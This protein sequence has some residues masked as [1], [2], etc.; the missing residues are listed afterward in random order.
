L[1]IA[2]ALN[3]NQLA[4]AQI[5]GVHACPDELD[6]RQISELA[7][8]ALLVKANFNPDEPRVPAGNPDGGEWTDSGE[9]AEVAAANDHDRKNKCIEECLYLLNR[10]LPYR[11]SNL[12]EFAFRR[13]VNECMQQTA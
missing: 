13:C 3:D 5:Y 2:E 6:D 9:S 1:R 11:W 10:R 4:P 8:T 12:N 7:V